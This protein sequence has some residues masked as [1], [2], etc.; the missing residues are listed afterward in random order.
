MYNAGVYGS[1]KAVET[2]SLLKFVAREMQ[3][4]NFCIA[5]RVLT[6]SGISSGEVGH[7]GV[8]SWDPGDSGGR[9]GR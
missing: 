3:K 8:L 4:I 2:R 1:G 6:C 9:A 5:L 7:L